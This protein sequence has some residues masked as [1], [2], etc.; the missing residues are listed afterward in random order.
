MIWRPEK[1]IFVYEV[2]F[3]FGQKNQKTKELAAMVPR[4][5]SPRMILSQIA[6]VYDPMEL[7]I[8]VTLEAKVMMR[9]TCCLEPDKLNNEKSR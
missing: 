6:R 2:H 5:V 1:D 8:P 7:A 4:E 9:K 3:H